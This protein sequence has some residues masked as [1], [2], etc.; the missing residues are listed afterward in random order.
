[1]KLIVGL[2][3]IGKQYEGTKHNIGFDV[4]TLLAKRWHVDTW[5]ECREAL[6]TE[7]RLPEKVYIIKPTTYMN[8]SGRAVGAWAKFYNI[9]PED[10]AVVQDD[11]DMEV[12]QTRIRDKGASGG[13]NGIKSITNALGTD[14][15]TRFKVGIGHPDHTQNAV[16][17]YVLNKFNAEQRKL[18]NEAEEN[19]ANA[20]ELWLQGNVK[21]MMQLYN[22]KPAKPKLPETIACFG[23]SLIA[24]FPFD[25]ETSWINKVAAITG[26]KMLNFG[27]NGECCDE[28]YY[29]LIN[30]VLPKECKHVIFM[31]GMND[32][33]QQRPIAMIIEDI[34]KVAAFC[35]EK[36]YKLAV[37]MPWLCE[38][39]AL[40]AEITEL[41]AQMKAQL[42][43]V[44]FLDFER[45]FAKI[46][47]R[48]DCFVDA[49]HPTAA[50]YDMLG[51][52]AAPIVNRW[53]KR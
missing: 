25:R 10:I 4:V 23:D 29:R 21:D 2:G 47:Y 32:I 14:A 8:N 26:N 15:F 6:Y 17:G 43:Y 16:I 52:F 19:M 22:K 40:N 18:I 3:N 39:A 37:A 36:H 11:M 45:A 31:G 28:I 35:K 12:G 13:H 34:Q 42:K 33:L 38:N 46:T 48:T 51:E 41:R 7:Y 50:T 44:M 20:L 27:E 49:V 1:M 30:Q 9:A 24:G 5:K 53:A